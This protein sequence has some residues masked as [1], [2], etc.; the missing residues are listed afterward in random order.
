ML[1]IVEFVIFSF[2]HL[3]HTIQSNLHS[4]L[5]FLLFS[6]FCFLWE[7]SPWPCSTV[8]ATVQESNSWSGFMV[9]F[10]IHTSLCWRDV[11]D[12]TDHSCVKWPR[13]EY[14]LTVTLI[15]WVALIS[16]LVSKQRERT[17]D[18]YAWY[19]SRKLAT[20]TIIWPLVWESSTV[21]ADGIFLTAGNTILCLPH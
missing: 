8:W 1:V 10:S 16:W 4:K 20:G 15:P 12:H 17:P 9:S 7:S 6:S 14:V 19:H 21:S 3:R 18:I 13:C 2:M 5:T 11:S